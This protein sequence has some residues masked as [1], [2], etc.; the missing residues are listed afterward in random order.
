MSAQPQTADVK[1]RANQTANQV[2]SHPIVQQGVSTANQ[3]A[4]RLDK[5]VSIHSM[6]A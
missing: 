2:K 6:A 1:A 4:A 5:H 3:Y